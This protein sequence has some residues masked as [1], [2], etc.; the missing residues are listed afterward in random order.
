MLTFQ[1]IILTLQDYWA[2]QGCVILQPYDSEVGAGTYHTA[3]ALRSLGPSDWRTA[4][5]QPCRRPA[6]GRYGANPNRMQHYYQFQVIMKPSPDNIQELYL[7]SL[8]TI[9]IEP[10]DSGYDLVWSES[11]DGSKFTYGDVFYENERE[12]SAYNFEFADTDMLF[13]R[14]DACERECNRLIGLGLPLPAYDCV[15][16]CSHAFN[17]LDARGA[18]SATERQHYILRVR[19]V[20]KACCESYLEHVVEKGGAYIESQDG[21]RPADD[22]GDEKEASHE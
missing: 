8:R 9:G 12:Q 16:K 18:I 21:P 4:Y 19:T 1:D 15:M 7:E 2:K 22:T 11:P 13:K 14:F 3:T 20:T 5:V 6:D 17:L 10:V